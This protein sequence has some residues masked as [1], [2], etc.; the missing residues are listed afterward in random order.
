MA[1]LGE[2]PAGI[3][4]PVLPF[5]SG[6][7]VITIIDELFTPAFL[8]T[9]VGYVLSIVISRDMA[10]KHVYVIRLLLVCMGFRAQV[11]VATFLVLKDLYS[12][13]LPPLSQR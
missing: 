6:S 3:P 8:I 13:Q 1:I 7:D 9:V 5:S 2:M 4:Q 10:V 11:V 12:L